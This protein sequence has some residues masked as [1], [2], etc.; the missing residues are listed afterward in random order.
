MIESAQASDAGEYIVVVSNENGTVESSKFNLSVRE[1][2]ITEISFSKAEIVYG[3]SS[4][5]S[6]SHEFEPPVTYPWK[7]YGAVISEAT[8]ATLDVGPATAR[9]SE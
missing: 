8:T 6:V 7:K 9:I 2:K 3:E 4:N 1:R 5:I